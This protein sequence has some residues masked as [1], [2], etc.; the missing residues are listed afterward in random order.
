MRDERSIRPTECPYCGDNIPIDTTVCPACQEDVASLIKLERWH[1][2]LYN[3]ALAAAKAGNLQDALRKANASLEMS[4]DFW[5]AQA[6]LAKIYA[7]RGA[8]ESAAQAIEAALD[9]APGDSSLRAL[10][11]SIA[12]KVEAHRASERPPAP[13]P[14]EPPEPP[15][16]AETVSAPQPAA[17]RTTKTPRRPPESP[18]VM[19]SAGLVRFFSLGA[20]IARFFQALGRM[21]GS[22]SSPREQRPDKTKRPFP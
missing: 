17:A 15:E 6:L 1:L 20:G 21:F 14:S 10:A 9:V 5:P 3:E 13:E 12:Q 22:G 8:W 11:D 16:P 19:W 18:R 4:D 7:H 2:I